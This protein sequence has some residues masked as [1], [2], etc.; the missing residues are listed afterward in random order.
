MLF[1][2]SDNVQILLACGKNTHKGITNDILDF[3]YKHLQ[4]YHIEKNL[5]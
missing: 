5:S 3:R 4:R 1:E 2:S